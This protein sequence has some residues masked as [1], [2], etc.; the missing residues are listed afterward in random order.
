MEYKGREQ[1]CV[2]DCDETIVLFPNK[3]KLDNIEKSSQGER[4][5]KDIDILLEEISQ[6][7]YEKKSNGKVIIA[8]IVIGVLLI[9]GVINAFSNRKVIVPNFIGES[10]EEA[11]NLAKQSKVEINIKERYSEKVQEGYVISQNIEN[12]RKVVA[13]TKVIIYVSKGY[14]MVEVPDFEGLTYQ[15]AEN[16]AKQ[17]GL[18]VKTVEQYSEEVNEGIVIEQ[19]YTYGTEVQKGFKIKLI[20]SKGKAPDEGKAS[21]PTESYVPSNSVVDPPVAPTYVEPAI[22]DTGENDIIEDDVEWE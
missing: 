5:L 16:L 13:G 2:K 8:G 19:N 14:E 20:I 21:Q 22:E 7:T 17:N 6:S 15:E 11:I 12:N 3:K 1:H 4:Q 18:Q 10:K 9:M